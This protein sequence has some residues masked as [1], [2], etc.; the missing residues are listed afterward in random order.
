MNKG[1]C[2]L[3]CVDAPKAEAIREGSP[4]GEAVGGTAERALSDPPRLMLAA[5]LREEELGVCDLA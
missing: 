5:A 4:G 2:D 3:L 1:R